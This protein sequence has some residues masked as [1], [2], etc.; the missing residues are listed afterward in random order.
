MGGS[1]AN[2]AWPC[3]SSRMVIPKDQMSA[4][5]LYLVDT[6]TR[7]VRSTTQQSRKMLQGL[8][9]IFT[10]SSE[11]AIQSCQ[12]QQSKGHRQYG[13]AHTEIIHAKSDGLCR[14]LASRA[15]VKRHDCSWGMHTLLSAP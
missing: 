5:L 1:L 12:V 6:A 7:S 4:R 10:P 15:A 11:A 8:D 14:H 3:A 13:F 9:Q 2:G